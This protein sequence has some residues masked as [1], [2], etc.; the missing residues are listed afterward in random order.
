M[1][2]PLIP[3]GGYVAS[4][5]WA[6]WVNTVAASPYV[7]QATRK[8]IYRRLGLNI[9]PNSYDL[10]SRC[11]FHSSE[12]TIGPQTIF[13]DHVYIE[14]VAPVTIG[15]GVGIGAH[16]VILTS[17]HEIGPSS[18]RNGRWFYEPV[19]IE[20]GCWLGARSV[21]LPGVTIGRGTIVGVGAVVTKDCEPDC[22]Y[23]G[24][25]ARILRRLEDASAEAAHA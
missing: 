14:N 5:A 21:V 4:R 19:V 13:N 25:P 10:G 1:R 16:A 8:R 9:S 2:N 17:N 23:A 22:V 12:I 3:R 15:S 24:V 7:G 18:Q 6:F 11:Y 20:D